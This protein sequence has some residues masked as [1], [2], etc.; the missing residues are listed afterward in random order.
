M[1]KSNKKFTKKDRAALQAEF[2]FACDL[3]KNPENIMEVREATQNSWK[4]LLIVFDAKTVISMVHPIFILQNYDFLCKRESWMRASHDFLKDVL[5]DPL[6]DEFKPI[7][8]DYSDELK[9]FGIDPD[10]YAESLLENYAGDF[11]RDLNGLPN[12]ISADRLLKSIQ[13]RDFF[14]AT[15]NHCNFSDFLR[16]FIDAGGDVALLADKFIDE[17]GYTSIYEE[18]S[19]LFDLLEAGCDID[20]AY[21]ADCVDVRI[22][23]NEDK[24]RYYNILKEHGADRTILEDF[25][26]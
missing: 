12:F 17:I 21:L 15:G 24:N 26:A 6:S 8:Q 1:K 9:G 5:S 22:I 23:N 25:V 10:V 7:L 16:N 20:V 3:A 18:F 19:A 2:D 4:D 14:D 11:V 13:I